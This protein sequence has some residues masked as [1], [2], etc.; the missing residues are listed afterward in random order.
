MPDT[1]WFEGTH[2]G[3]RLVKE[4]VLGKPKGSRPG[5]HPHRGISM[6]CHRLRIALTNHSIHPVH[7]SHGNIHF[8]DS[9]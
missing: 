2:A 3:Y 1:G 6:G 5:D 4:E 9:M 8:P 7:L